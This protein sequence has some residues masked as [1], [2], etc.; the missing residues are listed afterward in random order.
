MKLE[1]RQD[2]ERKI[3]SRIVKDALAGGYE[4][5]VFDGEEYPL[6]RSTSYKKIMDAGFSTDQDALVFF[7]DG[8]RLGWVS[9]IYGNS[10][11]DVISDYVANDEI[12]ALLT[13]AN[14]LADKLGE[15]YC[16]QEGAC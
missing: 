9:L 13:G 5:S 4:I 1:T 7:K 6:K 15:K 10:G 12:E 3:Y 11:W 2:I 16:Y 8:N 14:A